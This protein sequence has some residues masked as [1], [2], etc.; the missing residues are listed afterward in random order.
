MFSHNGDQ[1]TFVYDNI[2]SHESCVAMT[3][4]VKKFRPNGYRGSHCIKTEK[5]VYTTLN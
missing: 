1:Q 4:E 5:V 2:A 3:K